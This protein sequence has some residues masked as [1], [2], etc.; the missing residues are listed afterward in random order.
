M[1]LCTVQTGRIAARATHIRGGESVPALTQALTARPRL[2]VVAAILTYISVELLGLPSTPLAIMFGMTYPK[3]LAFVMAHGSSLLS[4]AIAF[5]VGR[6][7]LRPRFAQRI[8]DTPK[9][10]AIDAAIRD[11]DFATILLLRFAP[12]PPVINYI[13]GATSASF[14]GYLF[15]T[16]LGNSPGI[17]LCVMSSHGLALGTELSLGIAACVVFAVI[18]A[19]SFASRTV[20]QKLATYGDVDT[21][22]HHHPDTTARSTS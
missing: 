13:Y 12:M 4:G 6:T 8:R 21:R 16:L 18:F 7:T 2:G 5:H 1:R 9:L 15:A 17:A 10:R 19:S 11:H 14:R 20:S 3:P 22:P